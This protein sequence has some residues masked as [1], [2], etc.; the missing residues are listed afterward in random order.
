MTQCGERC[1]VLHKTTINQEKNQQFGNYYLHFIRA[2]PMFLHLAKF[3]PYCNFTKYFSACLTLKV[4][5]DKL[6][7]LPHPSSPLRHQ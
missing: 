3:L 1:S 4:F 2:T 7:N 6:L 5:L